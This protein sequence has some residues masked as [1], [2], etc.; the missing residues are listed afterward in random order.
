MHLSSRAVALSATFGTGIASAA[1]LPARPYTKAAP[2]Q[3]APITWSGCYLGANIGAGWDRFHAGEAG[4]AGVP[5]P[6]V[7][8]GS[9]TGT[10]LIGG[11]QVGCDYQ[12]A[13]NWVIG[14][15]GKAEFGN[16]NSSNLVAA[17]PGVTAVFKL[18][19][20][21][22]LTGRLGYTLAPT[23]LAY[24]KGGAAW[25]NAYATASTAFGLG[26]TANFS[27]TGYTVGGGVEWIFAPG[28]SVF[29]EYNYLDF[30]TKNVNFPSTG[31]GAGLRSRRY[32]CRYQCRQ[33]YGAGSNLRRELQVQLGQPDHR[34]V[35][36]GNNRTAS[37]AS[38]GLCS[39]GVRLTD[40]GQ[41][42]PHLC[43]KSLQIHGL[44]VEIRAADLDT[45]GTV[46][47]K[48][49]GCQ[50]DN[51]DGCSRRIGLDQ[52]SRFPAVHFA[53]GDI[54]QDQM[55]VLARGHR[56]AGGAVMRTADVE[57]VPLQA[58]GKHVPVHFVVF[59]QQDLMHGASLRQAEAQGREQPGPASRRHASLLSAARR[60]RACGW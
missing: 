6:F 60:S 19:N 24:V 16:I 38:A 40:R 34:E 47:G 9:N 25:S 17:F 28:W 37:A 14:T 53:Q 55:R 20:T 27:M 52:L 43:Q 10:S 51:R 15:Q 11:G 3:P 39:R 4:F 36:A 7:D 45:F 33:A 12:F 59:N 31:P 30:G 49:V 21:E 44:C 42:R 29:G 23:V 22:T 46:A 50:S 41:K 26:E 48:R 54:H 35:L 13:P 18:K 2:L 58:P 57:A 5:T 8:Y 56:D 1:D 32:A